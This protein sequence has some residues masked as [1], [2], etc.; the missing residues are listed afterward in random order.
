MVLPE[1]GPADTNT[2]T[3]HSPVDRPVARH[4]GLRPRRRRRPVTG[5]ASQMPVV[6]SKSTRERVRLAAEWMEEGA[7][8]R[9]VAARFRV[10]RTSPTGGA[11]RWSRAAGAGVQGPGGCALQAQPR[12]AGRAGRAARRRPDRVEPGGPV[13]DAGPHRRGRPPTVRR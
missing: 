13:L 2:G 8:D 9:E 10:T 4:R 6:P 12:P 5:W 11:A 7:S 1:D 3:T